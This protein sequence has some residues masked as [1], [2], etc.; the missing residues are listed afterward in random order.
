MAVTFYVED[1]NLFPLIPSVLPSVV[2]LS[3]IPFFNNTAPV[4]NTHSHIPFPMLSTLA[5]TFIICTAGLT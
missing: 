4:T 1:S 3:S 5:H 2:A